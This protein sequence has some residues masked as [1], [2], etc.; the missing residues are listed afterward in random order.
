MALAC[1]GEVLSYGELMREPTRWRTICALGVGPEKLVGLCMERS[2]K[3]VVAALGIMRAGGAYLPLDPAY[4][5]ER[6]AFM[7]K[8][9]PVVALITEE[10]AKQELPSGSWK[11]V[12]LSKDAEKIR[13]CPQTPPTPL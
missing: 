9:A 1:A 12:V 3:M 6:L 11:T 2:P 13:E 10:P 4:P 5:S 8:D 7:L